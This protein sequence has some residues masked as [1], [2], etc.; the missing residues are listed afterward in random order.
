MKDRRAEVEAEILRTW[1]AAVLRPY[2]VRGGRMSG[3]ALLK[4]TSCQAGA[5]RAAPLQ[6]P[7]VE[8]R[9]D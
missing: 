8:M 7:L 6:L 3:I 2:M 9:A 5:Q 1:G 4:W